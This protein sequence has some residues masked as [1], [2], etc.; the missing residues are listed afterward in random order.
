MD[1]RKLFLFLSSAYAVN[2]YKSLCALANTVN[3]GSPL[4]KLVSEIIIINF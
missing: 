3:L 2:L 4:S 1:D